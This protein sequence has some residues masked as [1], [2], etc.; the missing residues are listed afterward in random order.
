MTQIKKDAIAG[1]P[2]AR[3]ARERAPSK[4]ALVLDLVFTLILLGGARVLARSLIERPR[5]GSFV[6]AGQE[7]ADRRRR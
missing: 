6:R 3:P 2:R 1:Q 7:G 4:R 5:R